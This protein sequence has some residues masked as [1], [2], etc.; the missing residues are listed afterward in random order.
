ML[1]TEKSIIDLWFEIPPPLPPEIK[2]ITVDAKKTSLLIL[3]IQDMNCN[4]ERR[5][6][7]VASIKSIANLLAK[8]RE[9]EMLIIYS[10]TGS[11]TKEQIREEVKP[12]EIEPIVK[13]GVDKFYNTNLESLLK[14]RFIEA[15]IITGTSAHGA[16]L[17]TVTG[18]ATRGFSVIV[19][20]DCLSSSEFYSEQYTVWH[21]ANSPG[22]K[23]NTTLTKSAEIIFE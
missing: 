20:I 13:S 14:G 19:P 7:C 1:N 11:A 4:E 12:L 21:L 5:P 23:R 2:S 15:V 9:K 18:A 16:V 6:R 10:L 3:D 8:A 22:T 17:N